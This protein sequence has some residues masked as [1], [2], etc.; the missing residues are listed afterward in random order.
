MAAMTSSRPESGTNRSKTKPASLASCVE[1]HALEHPHVVALTCG[2]EDLTYTAL[3]ARANHVARSLLVEGVTAGDFVG[4]YLKRGVDLIVALVGVSKSGAAA[5]PIDAEYPGQRVRYIAEDS[6]MAVM[7]TSTELT[8]PSMQARTVFMEDLTSSTSMR[9][10]KGEPPPAERGDLA[11]VIYTSGTTGNP[12]GVMLTHG[13]LSYTC[14]RTRNLLGIHSGDV[15]AMLHSISFDLSHWAIFS[16]LSTGATLVIA[17]EHV[18]RSEDDLYALLAKHRVTVL[19]QTPSGFRL[20]DRADERGG[21]G[22]ELSLREV[23]LCGEPADEEGLRGWFKRHGDEEPAIFNMYGPTETTVVDTFHRMTQDDVEQPQSNIGRPLRGTKIYILDKF[24]QPVPAGVVGEIH[25]GG[26]GVAYGYLNKPELT[27]ARF[28]PDPFASATTKSGARLYK[29]GDMAKFLPNGEISFVGRA[30]DQVKVRGFRI[31]LGELRTAIRAFPGVSDAVATV[32]VEPCAEARHLVAYVVGECGVDVDP[33]KLLEH[34]R[35]EL[36]RH[37]VPTFIVPIEH[38]PLTSNG[39]LDY[40]ALPAPDRTRHLPR[41]SFVEPQSDLERTLARHWQRALSVEHVGLHDNFFDLGGD[42]LQ[43]A[44]LV[45]RLSAELGRKLSGRLILEHQTVAAMA[46][47]LEHAG[48]SVRPAKLPVAHDDEQTTLSLLEPPVSLEYRPLLSLIATGELGTVDAVAITEIPSMIF[49]DGVKLPEEIVAEG[50]QGVPMLTGV[51]ELPMGRIGIIALPLRDDDVCKDEA[52]LTKSLVQAMRLAKA[53]GAKKVSLMGLL[54][55]ASG[56]GSALVRATEGAGLPEVTTGHAAT[57]CAVVLSVQRILKEASRTIENETVGVLGIGSIGTASLRTLLA[58]ERHPR[59]L[60]LCDLFEK[61]E[62]LEA[63]ADEARK[64][65]DFA[66]NITIVESHAEV[67]ARFYDAS[68]II[69]ASSVGGILKVSQL[70]PGTLI[71]D[72]SLPHCFDTAQAIERL[73]RDGDILFTE[74]GFI[75]LREPVQRTRYMPGDLPDGVD[76][77]TL[78]FYNVSDPCHYH[79]CILSSLLPC[80][81]P[82]LALTVGA[83]P[84]HQTCDAYFKKLAELGASG[85]SLQCGAYELPA[86]QVAAFRSRFGG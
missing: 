1:R 27:E 28:I 19:I 80:V 11:C 66:G 8:L 50:M 32:H 84:D 25:I 73:D 36:P 29:S 24:L 63:L 5:V 69:G 23:I 6:G 12:K 21:H 39:K 58:H 62:A 72:D 47:A 74:G 56:Y 15:L 86:A 78:A 2:G 41:V 4:V 68:L 13:N 18:T 85:P 77:S 81:F 7:L 14:R 61:R 16:T 46:A 38:V 35:S 43:A 82:D 55:T 45:Q 49:G 44:S 79:S 52:A 42:S 3:N 26:P 53:V 83:A 40:D 75:Q 48:V 20:I 76:L 31:E 59:E 60:I 70:N 17:P 37:A 64:T 65:Y 51:D 9:P 33:S 54:G 34:L 71:V 10:C 67:P 30:D 57:A 22:T